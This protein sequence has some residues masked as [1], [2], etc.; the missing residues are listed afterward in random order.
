MVGKMGSGE[1]LDSNLFSLWKKNNPNGI[2]GPKKRQSAFPKFGSKTH[3]QYLNNCFYN[4]TRYQK[5]YYYQ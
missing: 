3:C 4:C 5:I 1:I 2:T